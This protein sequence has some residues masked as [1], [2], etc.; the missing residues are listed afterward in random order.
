MR[1][2]LKMPPWRTLIVEDDPVTQLGLKHMIQQAAPLEVVGLASDGQSAVAAAIRLSPDLVLMDIGLPELD[3]IQATQQIKAQRGKATKVIMLSAHTTKLEVLAALASG[4]EAYC[5]KGHGIPFLLTAIATV[6]QG[7]LYFDPKI[8]QTV[9]GQFQSPAS[10]PAESLT[11][12]LSAREQ[13][14][15]A[16]L[17]EGL[18]NPEIAKQLFISPN[19]V[20]SHVRGLMNKLAVSDRVQVAV[21]ALR[22]GLVG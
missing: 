3:G 11:T 18:S 5:V 15:L 8:A 4:A 1:Q 10:F 19:T 14:V 6:S 17:V 7:G 22:A 13:E 2:N 20:K 12:K 9:K 21:K 16:L